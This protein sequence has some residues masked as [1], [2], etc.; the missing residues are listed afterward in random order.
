MKR[1]QKKNNRKN[2]PKTMHKLKQIP[3]TKIKMKT[4]LTLQA[5]TM[6]IKK[7]RK[8]RE[9]LLLPAE[10]GKCDKKKKV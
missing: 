6:K 4:N 1:E 8:D 2:K 7:K 5:K 3:S 9:K 10:E